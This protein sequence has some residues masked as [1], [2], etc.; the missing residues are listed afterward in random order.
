M[1]VAVGHAPGVAIANHTREVEG[2]LRKAHNIPHRPLT[3]TEKEGGPVLGRR[4]E[5]NR[6]H[7]HLG[8]GLIGQDRDRQSTEVIGNIGRMAGGLVRAV[9]HDHSHRK[10]RDGTLIR[11]QSKN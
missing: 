6:D 7:A 2:I 11:Y 10:T 8:I 3:E 1:I 4:D 9:G 5:G